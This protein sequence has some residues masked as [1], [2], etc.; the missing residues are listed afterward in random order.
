MI[1]IKNVFSF[2]V[3]RKKV[4]GPE[5]KLCIASASYWILLDEK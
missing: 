3:I 4:I 1:S 2:F 5:K